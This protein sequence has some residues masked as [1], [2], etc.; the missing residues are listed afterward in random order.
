MVLG[1]DRLPLSSAELTVF[2]TPPAELPFINVGRFLARIGVRVPTLFH[3]DADAGVLL[4]EDV[5]DTTLRAAAEARD[6]DVLRFYR[7]AID[8]LVRLQVVGTREADPAC[9]AFQQR[10]DRRLFAWE[11]DHFLEYGIPGVPVAAHPPLRAAF[12][13]VAA[14]LGD[15]P[16]HLAHRDFHSWNLHVHGGAICVLDFQDALLAPATYDLASL[17]TD[18]DTATVINPALEGTLIDYYVEALRRAGT[19]PDDP[20]AVRDQ[21]FLCVL[22]RALKVVGRFHYLADVKGKRGYLSFLPHV[23]GQARRA[24]GA[25]PPAF[26]GLREALRAHL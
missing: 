5:G 2:A 3:H 16:A 10:F 26:D 20:R 22:Q 4:L 24:L 11:F 14:R 19:P 7:L 1:A 23:A 9:V 8:Q 25:L 15:A 18:R 6:A 21:Y 17:L 13:P 12:A